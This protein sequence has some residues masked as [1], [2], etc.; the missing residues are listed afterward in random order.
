MTYYSE[1]HKYSWY[2]VWP[3]NFKQRCHK[4]GSVV[5]SSQ[6]AAVTG[7]SSHIKHRKLGSFD[8]LHFHVVPC[9]LHRVMDSHLW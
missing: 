7:V 4:F 3:S 8:D 6:W 9:T 5:H 2:L 1:D